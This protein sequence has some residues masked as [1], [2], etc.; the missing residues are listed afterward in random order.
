MII[1]YLVSIVRPAFLQEELIHLGKKGWNLVNVVVLQ[2][3]RQGFEI[4]KPEIDI[5]YQLIFKK[6]ESN[7]QTGD[8]K[9]A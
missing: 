6:Y 5:Q 2:T 9:N 1:N 7:G 3:I 8:I 4:N